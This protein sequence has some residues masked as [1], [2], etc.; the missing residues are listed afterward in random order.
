M[1]ALLGREAQM[2]SLVG[3]LS[4][5]INDIQRKIREETKNEGL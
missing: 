1:K 3:Q 4:E 2:L 5:E